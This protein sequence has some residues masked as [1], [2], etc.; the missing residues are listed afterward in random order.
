MRVH[1]SAVGHTKTQLLRRRLSSF[2]LADITHLKPVPARLGRT[3]R[4]TAVNLPFRV[5]P[6]ELVIPVVP[7]NVL[8]VVN[9]TFA[10]I[11]I[12]GP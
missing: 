12:I 2:I 6:I 4:A 7:A 10:N 11:T 3:V 9:G 8:F 5:L 1:T